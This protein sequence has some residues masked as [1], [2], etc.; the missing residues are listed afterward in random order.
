MNYNKSEQRLAIERTR[1]A[2]IR[3][4]LAVLSFTATLFVALNAANVL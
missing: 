1:L 2:I 4:V 3:T